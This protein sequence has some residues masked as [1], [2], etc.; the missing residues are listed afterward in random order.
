MLVFLYIPGPTVAK[1]SLITSNLSLNEPFKAKTDIGP[2][3]IV[4]QRRH[5]LFPLTIHSLILKSSI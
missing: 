4:L 5:F 3:L 2:D 1:A